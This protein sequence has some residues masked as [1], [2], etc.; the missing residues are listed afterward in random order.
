MTPQQKTTLLR[1]AFNVGAL[2]GIALIIIAAVPKFAKRVAPEREFYGDLYKLN[3]VK[4]FQVP[5]I[6]RGE[7]NTTMRGEAEVITIGDSFFDVTYEGP[8]FAVRFEKRTERKTYNVKYDITK[9]IYTKAPHTYFEEHPTQSAT[10]L[11][12][13]RVERNLVNDILDARGSVLTTELE[14]LIPLHIRVSRSYQEY[15]RYRDIIFHTDPLI[16]LLQNS[17][18]TRRAYEILNTFRFRVTGNLSPLTPEYTRDPLMLYYG[19][20]LKT[21]RVELRDAE[22][23]KLADTIAE[24]YTAMRETQDIEPIFLPLPSK[25]TVYRFLLEDATYNNF[26]PRLTHEL[27]ARGV[28]VIDMLPIYEEYARAHDELLYYPTDTHWN[29]TAMKLL[30]TEIEGVMQEEGL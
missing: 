3:K 7:P 2:I 9:R 22:I 6:R 19:P 11:L 25:E 12:W 29:G 21:T 1:I 15:E 27:E 10:I 20:A 17:L 18:I 30:M 14:Q 26:L 5:I 8:T 4:D 28:R 23:E 24:E 16:F 13:E